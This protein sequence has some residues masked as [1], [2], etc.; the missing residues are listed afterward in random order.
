MKNKFLLLAILIISCTI[1]NAKELVTNADPIAEF[2]FALKGR[3]P[4]SVQFVNKSKNAKTY[5]WDF[6]DGT[7]STEENPSHIYT[8]GGPYIVTL[9]V[10]SKDK[11]DKIQSIVKINEKPSKVIVN[12]IT[13]KKMPLLQ[14][15]GKPWDRD[16][17]IELFVK[18]LDSNNSIL[19]K[20]SLICQDLNINNQLPVSVVFND[21]KLRV[22]NASY[23][24]TYMENDDW[25]E[26]EEVGVVS[27]N[28]NEYAIVGKEQYP[29]SI[30]IE[31][32]GLIVDLDLD[33]E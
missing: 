9:R 4:V 10:S 2:T 30:T 19:K 14:K 26:D 32:N 13:L 11:Q 21:L 17:G 31:Q 33:W 22:L 12:K 8:E 5:S 23:E 24:I 28:F 25:S 27:V 15:D 3:A 18:I 7:T 29:N 6:G 20:S 16:G 1:S